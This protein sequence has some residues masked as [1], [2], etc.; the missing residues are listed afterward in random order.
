MDTRVSRA[1]EHVTMQDG[2]SVTGELD[3]LNAYVLSSCD[4]NIC[5]H[6]LLGQI[7]SCTKAFEKREEALLQIL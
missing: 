3:E 6:E 7:D 5:C 2:L 1:Y 4:S